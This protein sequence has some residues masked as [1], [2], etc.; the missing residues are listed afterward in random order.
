MASARD[1]A[2]LQEI[3]SQRSKR[4]VTIR[5]RAEKWIAGLTA[6]VGVLATA[7]LVKGP[8]TFTDIPEPARYWVLGLL[9]LGGICIGTG[10]VAAYSAAFGGVFSTGEVDDL[11]TD[12]QDVDGAAT[13][14]EAAATKDTRGARN[15]LR[16]ALGMTIVGA[17]VLAGSVIVAWANP[18][19]SGPPVCAKIGSETVVFKELPVVKTGSISFVKC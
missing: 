10:L 11:L 4:L 7:T 14:L 3:D 19:D 15:S 1:E 12:P 6:L 8:E 5:A 9:V 17:L 2:A 16:L 13:R 18:G